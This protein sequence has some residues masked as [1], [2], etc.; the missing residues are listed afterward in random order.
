MALRNS[1]ECKNLIFL[2]DFYIILTL[3]LMS[4]NGGTKADERA[5][6]ISKR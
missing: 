6:T 1:L 4:G 2:V 5:A 3:P